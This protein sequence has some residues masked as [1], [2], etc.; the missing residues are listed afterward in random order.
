MSSNLVGL[1]ANLAFFGFAFA[2]LGIFNLVFLS[3]Y[4]HDVNKVSRPF[5]LSCVAIGAYIIIIEAACHIVPYFSEILDTPDPFIFNPQANNTIV[6]IITFLLLTL[7]SYRRSAAAFEQLDFKQGPNRGLVHLRI[8]SPALLG[9]ASFCRST[10]RRRSARYLCW[11]CRKYLPATKRKS[12]FLTSSSSISSSRV[13][14][15]VA[16]KAPASDR[17]GCCFQ[18]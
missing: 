5:I 6:G 17:A 12:G 9:L 16:L 18:K 7:L 3:C 10:S 14:P 2:L 11:A 4:Y 13:P 15:V 8:S 1:D